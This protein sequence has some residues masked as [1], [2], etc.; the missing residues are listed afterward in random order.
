LKKEQPQSRG[1]TENNQS[2]PFKHLS[3]MSAALQVTE[4]EAIFN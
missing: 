3:T 2:I 4:S 1:Y